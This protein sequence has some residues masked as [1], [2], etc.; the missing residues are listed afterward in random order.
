MTK[1]KP[2]IL[3]VTGASGSIYFIKLLQ[4][5]LQ[6]EYPVHLIISENA[7]PVI[8]QELGFNLTEDIEKN[9]TFL[10]EHFD[11]TS[12]KDL[13]V[14]HANSNTG[15]SIASGSFKTDG[16]IICPCSM[17]TMASIRAGMASTLITR[18]ADVCLKQGRKL[19]LAPREMPFSSIQLENMYQLSSIGVKIAIPCPAF[20][21]NPKGID[22]I[23]SFVTGKILDAFEVPNE[24]YKRWS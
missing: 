8:N 10:L 13:L 7:I 16:M 9:K 11:L 19:L 20:Y 5:L 4:F 12:K 21:N 14:I 17:N 2:I 6:E 1:T 3:G 18:T 22:D 24:I 23:I 15:A